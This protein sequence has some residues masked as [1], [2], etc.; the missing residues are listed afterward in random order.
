[1]AEHLPELRSLRNPKHPGISCAVNEA[2]SEAAEVCLARHHRPPKTLLTICCCKRDVKY[3]L[4]WKHPG[5]VAQRAWLNRD[6]AT[7]DG[8]YIIAI[9][10]VEK[11]LGL[12]ALSR[13]DTR[14]GADYYIGQPNVLDLEE[15]FRLEVSGIDHGSIADLKRR[16]SQK[17]EQAKQ[18]D[19]CLP[20]YASVVG[21][22]EAMVFVTRVEDT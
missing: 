3:N 19:S 17:E 1:M 15:A 12:I 14:T 7:R 8:A 5:K 6:D 9:A 21:F 11:E 2:F 4:N 18:G 22:K 16:L 10:V 13:T 20:A